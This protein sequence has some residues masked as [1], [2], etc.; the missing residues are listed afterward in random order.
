[1][2]VLSR[3]HA[4]VSPGSS[5][6]TARARVP[7]PISSLD[8]CGQMLVP[9]RVV[10]TQPTLLLLDEPFAGINPV[11]CAR[12]S[13]SIEALCRDLGITFLIIEHNL[14][15]VERLCSPVIVMALGR[16]IAEGSMAELRENPAVVDAYLGEG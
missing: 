12:L 6:R 10:M 1:M 16:V 15:M 4:E 8:F 3:L 5:G 11:L 7:Q 9:A 13:A 2:I 14:A